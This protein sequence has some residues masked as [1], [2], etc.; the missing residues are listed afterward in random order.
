MALSLVFLPDAQNDLGEIFYY[1]E[2]KSV[3]LGKDS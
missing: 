2:S 1:Y 3:G